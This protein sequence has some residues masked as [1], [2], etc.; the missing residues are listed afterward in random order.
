MNMSSL[1]F[2]LEAVGMIKY[3]QDLDRMALQPPEVATSTSPGSSAVAATN[4]SA[5]TPSLTSS[6]SG[7][8]VERE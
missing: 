4:S 5:E 2:K 7:G 8:D 6:Q 1:L 3:D